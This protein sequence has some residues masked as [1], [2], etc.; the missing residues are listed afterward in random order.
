MPLT[1]RIDPHTRVVTI[2]GDYANADEWRKLL[3]AIA[4]D[5]QYRRGFN[6]IRDLRESRHP[7]D[8]ATVIGIIG[9]VR[10]HWLALGARRAAIVMGVHDSDPALV[11]HALASHHDLPIRAF[12]S[13]DDA[14]QWLGEA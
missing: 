12:T 7:V 11:A 3:G 6:F 9:I 10:Q 8:A 13:Y 5:P 14:V 2:T 4:A 1:Y